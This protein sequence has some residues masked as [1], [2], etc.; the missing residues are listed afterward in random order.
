MGMQ[1][2]PAPGNTNEHESYGSFLQVGA[3]VSTEK[4]SCG[5]VIRDRGVTSKKMDDSMQITMI[6]HFLPC[7]QD[8]VRDMVRLN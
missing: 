8:L 5:L 2:E 4:P 3:S 7:L 6:P 1:N